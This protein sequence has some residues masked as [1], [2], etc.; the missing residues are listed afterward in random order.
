VGK[1]LPKQ[2]F[3]QNNFQKLFEN[4]LSLVISF[5]R[6]CISTKDRK[7]GMCCIFVDIYLVNLFL[8]LDSGWFPH[9]DIHGNRM[10]LARNSNSR[11]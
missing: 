9:G 11:R 8:K 5:V 6:K 2:I 1:L 10:G 4:K 3:L 7:S